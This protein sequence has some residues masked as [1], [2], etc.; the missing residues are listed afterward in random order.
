MTSIHSVLMPFWRSFHRKC[1]PPLTKI[2]G[3]TELQRPLIWTGGS[4]PGYLNKVARQF[5]ERPRETSQFETRRRNLTLCR[6]DPLSQ[7][8]ES[9]HP[10]LEG[11]S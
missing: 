11:K 8:P 1:L 5:N 10:C 9:A 3:A 6:D 4:P 2:N 7:N